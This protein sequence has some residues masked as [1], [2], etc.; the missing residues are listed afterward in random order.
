MIRTT[1]PKKKNMNWNAQTSIKYGAR[2]WAASTWDIVVGTCRALP[3][4]GVQWR[5]WF[6]PGL[7]G[8]SGVDHGSLE[9]PLL[10][11]QEGVSQDVEDAQQAAEEAYE[12]LRHEQ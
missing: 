2:Y 10:R 12:Q 8:R 1:A 3:Q 9:N 6:T 11:L 7:R 4:G 5:V